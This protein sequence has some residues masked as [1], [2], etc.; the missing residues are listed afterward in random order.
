MFEKIVASVNDALYSYI[1]II[2]LVL[3]GLYFTFRSRF[4][5]FRLLREQFRAVTE[6]PADGRVCPRFRRLWCQPPPA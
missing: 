5:Q 1:L 4:V 6:K 2:I 3:G